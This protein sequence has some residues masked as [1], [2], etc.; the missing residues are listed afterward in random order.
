MVLGNELGERK[1]PVIRKRVRRRHV[2]H[3]DAVVI[4]TPPEG[5]AAAEAASMDMYMR[6]TGSTVSSNSDA[7]LGLLS[8]LT[9][10]ISALGPSSTSE[11]VG[12]NIGSSWQSKTREI[13]I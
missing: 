12:D 8:E 13:N 10:K 2:Q 11:A 9:T 3:P 5:V 4:Q 6:A 1:I 7:L